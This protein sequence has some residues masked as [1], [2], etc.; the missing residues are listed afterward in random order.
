MQLST[1]KLL[2]FGATVVVSNSRSLINS[3]VSISGLNMMMINTYK[4]CGSFFFFSLFTCHLKMLSASRI[5]SRFI[6]EV[7]RVK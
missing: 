2:V 4:A 3:H 6:R 1:K 5:L 7:K